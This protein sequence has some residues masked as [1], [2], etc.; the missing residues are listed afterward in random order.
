[1]GAN[2]Q[3]QYNNAGD[4]GGD[5][6]FTYNDVTNTLTVNTISSYNQTVSNNISTNTA[7]VVGNLTSGNASLGNLATAN[8]INVNWDVSANVIYGNFLYGDGSNLTN[9]PYSSNANYAAYA[10]EA[11][12]VSGSNVVG[13]VA[14]ANYAN[15]SGNAYS[16]DGA[17]VVGEVANANYASFANVANS[18]SSPVA[19]ANYA[20]FAGNAFSV[21]GANVVG[22]V[23]NANYAMH[24]DVEPVLDNFSYH[25]VLVA[26]PGD[27]HLKV[28]GDDQLQ[29]NPQFGILTSNRVDANLFVGNGHF[30]TDLT[31]A[32]VT[33]EVPYANIANSV[34]GA[35]VTGTVANANYAAFAG[36][37]N[38]ASNVAYANASNTANSAN[39]SNVAI[40]V[41]G[42]AQPNITSVGNLTTLNVTGALF[43]ATG[44]FSGNGSFGNLQVV[45]QIRVGSNIIANVGSNLIAYGNVDFY[46]AT[47]VNLGEI[48]EL[49]ISGGSNGY[50]L[51]TDGAGNLSW[52]AVSNGGNAV[53]PPGGS[54][55]QLQYNNDGNFAGSAALVFD[56]TSNVLT[57]SGPLVATQ[58][59]V[60]GNIGGANANLGN[61]VIANF[62][63]GSGNRLS[64]IQGANVSGTVA[65]ANY[66]VSANFA[67]TAT[68]ANYANYANIASVSNLTLFANTAN[69]VVVNAQP[70]ITSVGNL[71]SLVVDGNLYSNN[72]NVEGNGSY[73]NLQV[74]NEIRIGNTFIANFG[75]NLIAYGNVDFYNATDVN[76]GEVTELHIA[77]GSNGYFLRTDG[78]GNLSWAAVSNGSNANVNAA[79]SNTQV[80]FN[81]GNAFGASAAFVFDKAANILTITGGIVASSLG[82]TAN[83]TAA[84]ATLGNLVVA[85]F[86]Q[87][88]GNRLSNIQGA[89]VNGEVALANFATYSISANLA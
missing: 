51:R 86:F 14:N 31:G 7:I 11:F 63:Q 36:N 60:S 2:T 40:T 49:H 4:F 43:A 53:T 38:F 89:N 64:N 48:T 78:A 69:T 55:T 44:N 56:N 30:L 17:N 83:I 1:G 82:T 32:N 16:V 71:V 41:S 76:L 37:A 65:N 13:D 20:N 58:L 80:Q 42:N 10:G 57:V 8:Y 87:G 27:N 77:G 81:D 45:N 54:N 61:L 21:D 79:G 66:A 73:G 67:N 23:A 68:N 29:Y 70:N 12:L 59:S 35:N 52:A 18:V 46:N 62:F 75:S 5:A 24:V 88:S 3:V 25:V 39:T 19:N 22:E 15:F 84:N 33:G 28:D 74:V 34:A 50:F 26:N 85:N 72:S 47:D 6:G 9:L